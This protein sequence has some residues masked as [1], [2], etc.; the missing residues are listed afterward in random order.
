[1]ANKTGLMTQKQFWKLPAEE[2]EEKQKK[3]VRLKM[4]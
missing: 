2:A 4:A 1:M 3:R